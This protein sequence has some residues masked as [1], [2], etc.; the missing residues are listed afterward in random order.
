MFSFFAVEDKPTGQYRR[1]SIPTNLPYQSPFPSVCRAPGAGCSARTHSRRAVP[2]QPWQGGGVSPVCGGTR[3]LP[4]AGPRR[5]PTRARACSSRPAVPAPPPRLLSASQG[6]LRWVRTLRAGPR[7]RAKPRK[8]ESPAPD[9][10]AGEGPSGG[11]GTACASPRGP[12]PAG[13]P[14]GGSRSAS[15]SGRFGL[16]RERAAVECFPRGSP[17]SARPSRPRPPAALLE[18]PG[19]FWAG[20]KCT[21]LHLLSG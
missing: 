6:P 1:T 4:E 9:H 19:G 8:A 15:D 12:R 20:F 7:R 3:R 14:P 21:F 18:A 5:S 10:T 17:R 13:A 2:T 11:A 16:A